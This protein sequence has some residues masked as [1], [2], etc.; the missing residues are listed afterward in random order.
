MS[1]SF[2]FFISV[3]QRTIL[4]QYLGHQERQDFTDV[5]DGQEN[6]RKIR[7]ENRLLDFEQGQLI[8]LVL[9]RRNTSVI[10]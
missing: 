10:S 7:T 8:D 3:A 9:K 5:R 4:V 6:P 1:L 2:H